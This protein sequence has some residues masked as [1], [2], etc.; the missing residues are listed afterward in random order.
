M[1][2]QGYM[3]KLN[4]VMEW[5]TRFFVLQLIWILFSFAGL[6]IGGIFPA[7]F[8]MFAISRKWIH[9]QTEFP[10]F[11]TFWELYR[12]SFVKTN[13]L[14]WVITATGFSLYYYYQLLKGPEDMMGTV[15]LIVVWIMGILYLMTV[16]FI[17]PVYVHFDIKLVN[18]AKYALIIAIGNPFHVLSMAAL[19]VGFSMVIILIPGL[20]PFF[21]FSL[22]AFGLMWLANTAFTSMERKTAKLLSLKKGRAMDGA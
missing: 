19:V 13:L 21:S 6:I 1:F 7:T 4:T 18:V 15:L 5:I 10:I 8:T 17:M 12:T 22:L 11:R 3:G 14:G 20:I 9:K 16:L 2:Q